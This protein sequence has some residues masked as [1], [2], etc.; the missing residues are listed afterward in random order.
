MTHPSPYVANL[1][2]RLSALLVLPPGTLRDRLLM[3]REAAANGW[4]DAARL[5]QQAHDEWHRLEIGSVCWS[6]PLCRLA[7]QVS[8]QEEE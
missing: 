1:D 8:L 5:V 7:Q 6:S 4:N 3:Q 2:T